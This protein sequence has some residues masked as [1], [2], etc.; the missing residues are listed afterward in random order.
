MHRGD[1]KLL[2]E[3]QDLH[4]A[5]RQRRTGITLPVKTLAQLTLEL[6]MV[7]SEFAQPRHGLL[8]GF[9]GRISD[10]LIA[11]LASATCVIRY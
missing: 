7:G 6:G 10:H 1:H 11:H 3:Q 9:T 8:V 5:T 4:H 2:Q